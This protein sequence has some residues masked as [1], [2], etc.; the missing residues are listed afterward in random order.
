MSTENHTNFPMLERFSLK[1][2]VIVLTGGAG[3]YGRGMAKDLAGAG[4]T[5]VI[6]SRDLAACEALA[7][8][9]CASGST[10]HAEQLDQGSE[11]SILA[12]RD[13][14][15]ATFGR[16]DGL[17]NN[18]VVRPMRSAEASVGAWEESMKINATGVFLMHRHFGKVMTDQYSG[19]IVNIGSIQGMI[20]PDLGLYEGLDM[21]SLPPDYFF[22]KGGMIN[23]TRYF[24]ALFGEASVRVNCLSPGGFFN[25][26][27]EEFVRRYS[28]NTFL[29]R[30]GNASDLGGSVVF[31][32]SDAS[33]YI[34]GANLPVDGGYTAK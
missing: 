3:L 18:A 27:A 7:I 15:M 13:R 9:I 6:A 8:E 5:L 25:N 11:A 23:L 29:G 34:T 31:L 4:A 16:V 17:V 1:N 33:A 12:L 26:Q 32:L 14:V 19:S 2:K 30:M 21:P 10:A 22:H 20:G 28:A 24:A